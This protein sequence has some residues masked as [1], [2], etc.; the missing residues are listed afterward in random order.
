MSEEDPTEIEEQE[1][2]AL[3]EALERGHARASLPEDALETAAF[4]RYSRD[5]GELP[6]VREDAVLEGLL[7]NV[8]PRERE[9][10][11]GWKWLV[12]LVPAGGLAATAAAL[13][14]F[15]QLASAPGGEPPLSSTS[16]PAPSA[17]LVSTQLAV[18]NGEA[19]LPALG[20]QM[21]AY[22]GEV[23]AALDERYGGR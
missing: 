4:L 5:A 9:K 6:Q 18:A 10:A 20:E 13:L 23:L 16:L 1:A 19:E 17:T 11:R 2:Q 8:K 15:T 3:V 12:W 7:A 21:A 14:V 22:R